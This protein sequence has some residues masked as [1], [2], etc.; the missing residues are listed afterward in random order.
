MMERGE[1]VRPTR[2]VTLP[3]AIPRRPRRLATE[4]LLELWTE[5]QHCRLPVL[6]WLEGPE[7]TVVVEGG[8]VL[9][10]VIV[11]RTVLVTGMMVV[12]GTV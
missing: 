10:T 2:P 9:V 11:V 4:A 5:L 7:G 8:A 6:H 3:R 1:Q 12:T